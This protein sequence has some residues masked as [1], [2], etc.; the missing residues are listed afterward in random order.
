[1]FFCLCQSQ[2][3]QLMIGRPSGPTNAGVVLMCP[4]NMSFCCSTLDLQKMNSQVSLTPWVYF[5]FVYHSFVDIISSSL[6]GIPFVQVFQYANR[7][8]LRSAMSSHT[9]Q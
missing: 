9:S 1:M 7:L 2:N 5:R 3:A 6:K 4:E 8:Q